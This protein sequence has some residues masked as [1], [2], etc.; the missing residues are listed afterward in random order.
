MKFHAAKMATKKRG[1]EG[2]KRRREIHNHDDH[3]H[4][5]HRH[6]DP[7]RAHIGLR[8]GMVPSG[9]RRP[10]M[11]KERAIERLESYEE[12]CFDLRREIEN[13]RDDLA[14]D[15]DRYEHDR[16]PRRCD[17][18]RYDYDNER[19]RHDQYD[20]DRYDYDR[21][22]YDYDRD[23]YDYDRYD[24]DRDRYDYDRHDNSH[25]WHGR[26]DDQY[27]HDLVYRGQRRP[28]SPTYPRPIHETGPI[29][30]SQRDA[31][32]ERLAR[33]KER[34]EIDN[35]ASN[36]DP[37]RWFK[38]RDGQKRPAGQQK[39]S[40]TVPAE[41]VP[42]VLESHQQLSKPPSALMVTKDLERLKKWTEGGKG[43]SRYQQGKPSSVEIASN[44]SE[45]QASSSSNEPEQFL[46]PENFKTVPVPV[47]QQK[48]EKR[49]KGP[50][51]KRRSAQR[52][53]KYTAK[54]A[55]QRALKTLESVS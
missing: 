34:K 38:D 9:Q 28:S 47:T 12:K 35:L 2:L 52:F 4:H 45:Q 55:I 49:N 10:N 18:D 23:R 33:W 19:N 17:Y 54:M 11:P 37:Y 41:I 13:L 32:A 5:G 48:K 43:D 51:Q 24:Y 53:K 40:K 30:E 16:R 36:P 39:P 1:A 8:P 15:Y 3:R 14:S 50:S 27:E 6:R 25:D 46:K 29:L 7:D 42:T 22:R 21:D 26:Y 20:H 31:D 44:Q